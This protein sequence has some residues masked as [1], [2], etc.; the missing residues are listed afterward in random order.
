MKFNKIYIIA[1]IGS[2]HDGSF[3]NAKNLIKAAANCG[4]D[5]VKFQTHIAEAET[6]PDAPSPSYFK[7]ESRFE[8]FKR[9]A[10]SQEQLKKLKSCCE[11]C[12]VEFI[13]SAFSEEA[14][15]VLE[16]VGVRLHKVPS[17][18]VTNLPL[19]TKM[20]KTGKT[21]L[22][23]SGMSDYKEIDQAIDVIRSH[24]ENLVVMQCTSAYPCEYER[25]GLNVLKEFKNRFNV[26][27]GLS[28]HTLTAY[29][30]YAAVM[31]DAK[32]IEKHFTLSRLM[33]GSD[34]KNSLE[35]D[36]FR[37][38]VTGI[39]AIE[40]M[41]ANNVD[42]DN[43]SAFKDM[44]EIFQKSIVSSKPINKGETITKYHIGIK[45]PGTGLEP[46]YYT[47]IIGKKASKDISENQVIRK[48]DISWEV[49]KK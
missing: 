32:V 44:K 7:G 46:K 5:A 11:E 19:L 18:E 45:K 9:T 34:A 42:K 20:A 33:Y 14:V 17:G 41:L 25:I 36:E 8:Y 13:S 24:N 28:D 49:I 10:F 23:S 35:P 38:L 21:I 22:L 40:T 1:E 31:M 26:D 48:E 47:E 37:D 30:S 2:C 27:I 12:G 3:G 29:S 6:L 43:I 4:V 15:D 39:R 16:K